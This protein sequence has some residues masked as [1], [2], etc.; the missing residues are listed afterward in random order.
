M[1]S[2]VGRALVIGQVAQ[3]IPLNENVAFINGIQTCKTVEQR[4]F[5]AATWPHDS[6]HLALS[7]LHI[8]VVQGLDTQLPAVIDF[9]YFLCFNDR[10]WLFLHSSDPGLR[11]MHVNRFRWYTLYH[12]EVEHQV[13]V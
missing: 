11:V 4:C 5:A 10:L 7:H 2:A 1:S 9:A 12:E 13:P 3:I 8:N 6:H